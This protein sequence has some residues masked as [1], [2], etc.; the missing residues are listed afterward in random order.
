MNPVNL[1]PDAHR[2][3][4]RRVRP[5]APGFG[6]ML[7]LAIGAVA[8]AA[9]GG[10]GYMAHDARGQTDR[11]EDEIAVM[12]QRRAV[13]QAELQDFR[14]A[15]ARAELQR[16][17][18]GAV[19]ALVRGRVDWQ[20]LIR[21]TATAIPDG[22]WLTNLTTDSGAPAGPGTPAA[23]GTAAQGTG[24]PPAIRIDGVALSQP[25]VARLLVRLGSVVGLGEP[26]LGSSVAEAGGEELVRYSLAVQVDQRAQ[27][28]AVLV[29]VGLDATGVRP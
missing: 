10:L 18:N 19:V 9:L 17:R 8:V 2:Q 3:R 1:L 14:A 23:D 26:V 22:V 6:S 13:V 5:V 12:T 20:R 15:S 25:H 16:A 29:P 4:R 7:P 21:D 27:G 28:R 24:T 11:I